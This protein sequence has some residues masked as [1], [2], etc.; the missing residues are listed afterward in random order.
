ME[1]LSSETDKQKIEETLVWGS[2]S[3]G[4]QSGGE[5]QYIY[6]TNSHLL[7]PWAQWDGR[8]NQENGKACALR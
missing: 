2:A 4:V 5:A 1:T 6:I 3:V 7:A 8:E